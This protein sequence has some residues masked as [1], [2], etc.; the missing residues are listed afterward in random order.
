MKS[1]FR[2]SFD[3]VLYAFCGNV[4]RFCDVF[5]CLLLYFVLVVAF[6]KFSTPFYEFVYVS[7]FNVGQ[8]RFRRFHNGKLDSIHL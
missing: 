5:L 3:C 6:V 4:E 1:I 2:Q 7:G 8:Q